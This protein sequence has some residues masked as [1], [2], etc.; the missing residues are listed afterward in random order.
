MN[1]RNDTLKFFKILLIS[2][3]FVFAAAIPINTVISY[4]QDKF[5]Q[6]KC[7]GILDYQERTSCY[8]NLIKRVIK[9]GN[10]RYSVELM[11]T[12]LKEDQGDCHSLAHQ[13]GKNFYGV[14]K[15]G[16]LVRIGDPMT[17][18]AYGF[19]HGFMGAAVED[20]SHP[21]LSTICKKM[22]DKNKALYSECY[23]GFGLGFVGDPPR[24]ELW[25][26]ARD[27]VFSGVKMCEELTSEKVYKND[28]Y[29]G[30]FHQIINYIK[31][32]DYKYDLTNNE[33][34][35]FCNSFG[36]EYQEACLLQFAPALGS[37]THFSLSKLFILFENNYSKL[38]AKIRDQM[39]YTM[40]AG[41]VNEASDAEVKDYLVLCFTKS[42]IYKNNCIN[43]IFG[44]IFIKSKE[45]EIQ[46]IKSMVN[47][48]TEAPISKSQKDECLEQVSITAKNY[49]ALNKDLI[50][51]CKE[52]Q[53]ISC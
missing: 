53:L 33:I 40:V 51:F 17:I 34:F 49:K 50:N 37:L 39:V 1:F 5:E 52:Q 12:T 3:L 36:G 48:C 38:D 47:M 9:E 14:V 44:G 28:C 42:D 25:G 4:A 21:D 31:N 26:R 16:R 45:G 8:K 41:K 15:D 20:P 6:R 32:K 19:W 10:V 11:K 13:L 46:A 30:V 27:T 2:S 43:G 24:A 22:L 7:E 35:D 23:H 18:C 29:T